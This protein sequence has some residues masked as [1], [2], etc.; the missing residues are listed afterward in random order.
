MERGSEGQKERESEGE[1]KKFKF[2]GQFI[3]VSL[4]ED[5][6]IILFSCQKVSYK[7]SCLN[8]YKQRLN[9]FQNTPSKIAYL[10]LNLRHFEF[11]AIL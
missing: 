5:I 3:P 9:H 6:N 8:T 1:K 7:L 2:P 11:L 10:F 4:A